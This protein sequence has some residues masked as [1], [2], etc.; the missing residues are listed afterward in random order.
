MDVVLYT[1]NIALPDLNVLENSL[2][3]VASESDEFVE[4]KDKIIESKLILKLIIFSLCKFEGKV[5]I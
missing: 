3:K 1:K 2:V 4:V 5:F